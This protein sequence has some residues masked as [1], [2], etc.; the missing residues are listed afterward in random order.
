[1]TIFISKGEST[2]NRFIVY[3][4]IL[5]TAIK[6]LQPIIFSKSF[7][8]MIIPPLVPIKKIAAIIIGFIGSAEQ[9]KI[10]ANFVRIIKTLK[11]KIRYFCDPVMG[12]IDK[13]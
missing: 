2:S 1:M 9:V 13:G 5:F 3:F 10:I 6:V 7:P 12:D 11:P 8:S 4:F